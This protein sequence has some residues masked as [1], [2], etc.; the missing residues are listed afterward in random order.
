MIIH[1]IFH[2]GQK[3]VPTIFSCSIFQEGLFKKNKTRQKIVNPIFS[4]PI[5]TMGGF[6]ISSCNNC[7]MKYLDDKGEE[8]A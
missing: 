7:V 4:Y 6:E 2:Q 1:K 5:L 8:V 3:I